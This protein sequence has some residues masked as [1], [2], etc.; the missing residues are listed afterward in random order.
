MRFPHEGVRFLHRSVSVVIDGGVAQKFPQ[1]SF[2]ALHTFRHFL[3]IITEYLQ[4]G[5][6]VVCALH[7]FSNVALFRALYWAAIFENLA[8]FGASRDV[9]S[10]VAKKTD[11]SNRDPRIRANDILICL[12]QAQ[13]RFNRFWGSAIFE[14][15]TALTFP[16]VTPSR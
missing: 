5:D 1:G 15:R 2:A 16:I 11:G 4:V 13:F 9:D 3:Y 12:V 8:R 14:M 10:R 6:E 7:N